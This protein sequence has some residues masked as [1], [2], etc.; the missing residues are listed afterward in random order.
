[1]QNF[2]GVWYKHNYKG[3]FQICIS[4]PL[5]YL[6]FHLV[7]LYVSKKIH[8]PTLSN[9]YKIKSMLGTTSRYSLSS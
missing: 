9:F 1:M 2:Q 7:K 3:Y 8:T 4:V 5:K 6:D